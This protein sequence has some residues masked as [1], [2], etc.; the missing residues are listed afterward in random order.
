MGGFCLA[1]EV[2]SGGSATNGIAMFTM[3]I[4]QNVSSK[5]SLLFWACIFSNY[6]QYFQAM[7]ACYAPFRLYVC[8]CYNGFNICRVYI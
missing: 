5:S 1:V 7:I 2:A 6:H 3:S 4:R 8:V